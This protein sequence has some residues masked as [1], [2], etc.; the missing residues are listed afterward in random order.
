VTPDLAYRCSLL[1]AA[2]G[3]ALVDTQ[4]QPVPKEIHSSA[5]G[6]TA[7]DECRGACLEGD[8]LASSDDERG[9]I[10]GSGNAVGRGAGGR[11]DGLEG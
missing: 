10:R 5:S 7:S 2:L 1:T 9:R 3:F 6:S 11:V 8:V 4:G